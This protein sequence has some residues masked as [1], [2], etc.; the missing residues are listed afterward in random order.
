MELKPVTAEGMTKYFLENV[1][2]GYL[3]DDRKLY[4]FDENQYAVLVSE[5]IGANIVRSKI[6]QFLTNK[7]VTQAIVKA[8]T[9]VP[10]H[11]AD[12]AFLAARMALHEPDNPQVIEIIERLGR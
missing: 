1:Y 3:T 11:V 12:M 6:K 8:E 5:N 10:D 4:C 7:V 9:R 2:V